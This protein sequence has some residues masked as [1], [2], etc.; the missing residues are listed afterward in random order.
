MFYEFYDLYDNLFVG[1]TK[2]KVDSLINQYNYHSDQVC[3]KKKLL[4]ISEDELIEI[5]EQATE[6][7]KSKL[8]ELSFFD[9]LD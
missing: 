8:T 7:K 2:R 5:H 6:L 9:N 1:D 3:M 4:N